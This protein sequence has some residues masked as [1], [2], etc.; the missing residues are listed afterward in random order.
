MR[1]EELK[2]L[3]RSV[4][5]GE[6]SPEQAQEK[7]QNGMLVTVGDFVQFDTFREQRSGIPEVVYAEKKTPTL[8][9][10]IAKKI[11]QE[12]EVVLFTRLTST[13]FKALE[14]E[15]LQN[16]S[17]RGEVDQ[18]GRTAIIHSC[19]FEIPPAQQ[20]LVGVVTAGSS[21]VPVAREAETVL[22]LMGVDVLRSYDIGVAGLH[23]LITPLKQMV[24]S[25]V[26]AIIVFAGME[27][28]LPSVVAG[29]VDIPVL[30]V[31]VSVG[32]GVRRPGE[33]ALWG[34]LSSCSPGLAVLNIDAG[35]N[36][37]A[38]AGLIARRRNRKRKD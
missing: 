1:E 14:E 20:G 27:G 36:A 35:F 34:M 15:L 10:E 24:E 11:V 7:I 17:L 23:R 16:T 5:Q 31:P 8:C 6:L 3:L 12:K 29:L 38:M 25:D 18:A 13:H 22:R 21:D 28:A 19:T 9:V 2:T 37:G 33:V 26:D 32:Y 4:A 30:A